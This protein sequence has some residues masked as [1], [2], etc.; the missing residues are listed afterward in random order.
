MLVQANLALGIKLALVPAV[1]IRLLL[2]V[3]EKE[4]GSACQALN[5]A[6]RSTAS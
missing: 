6:R 1:G 2:D 5:A 3:L 4:C